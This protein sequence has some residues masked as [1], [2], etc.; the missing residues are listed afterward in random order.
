[1]GSA[2][3][4][5]RSWA[6][7]A[8]VAVLAGGLGY[9][10]ADAADLVPGVLT[11]RPRPT[12]APPFPVAPGA[13]AA[14]VTGDVLAPVSTDAPV[15]DAEALGAVLAPLLADPALGASVGASVVDGLTGE[16]LFRSDAETP[17]E[18]ASVAKLLTT[19]AALSRLGPDA[20]VP[21]RAVSGAS[22]DEVVLVGG[23]DVL[24]AAG[25]GDPDAANGRAGLGDL[26]RAT[27]A[28]LRERERTT[29]AVRLDDTLFTGPALGPGVTQADVAHGFVAAVSSV[30]V[31]AGRLGDANYAPRSADPALAAAT[32]FADRLREQGIEVVG[33]VARAK[34]PARPDVLGEV[35]SAPLDEVV[36]YTLQA[37]D[38]N[39]AEAL[40]RLVAVDMGRATTFADAARAVLDQVA[41]LGVDVSGARLADGSGLS[42]GSALPA[43]LLTDVLVAAASG[44]HPELRT[45]LTGLPVAGLT[46]TLGSRFAQ[47]E[48]GAGLGVVRAKTGSLLGTTS[49]AGTVRDRDGRLLVFAVLADA[50]PATDPAR[51]AVDDVAAALAAC[52]CGVR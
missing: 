14:P 5:R 16:P 35:R 8:V 17:R 23:G 34:A 31:D 26:A 2:Q 50:V 42:D 19:S 13:S 28:S 41:T 44:D 47:D 37:S 36:A 7:V 9:A 15:P 51:E 39:A 24:L 22:P 6:A 32:A 25:A 20:T 48:A 40:A 46:G 33:Q 18:P 49:L 21:T 12:P 43:S 4:G 38:N 11:T 3:R 1:M 45:V 29:V 27:A 30:A 10:G 52:G